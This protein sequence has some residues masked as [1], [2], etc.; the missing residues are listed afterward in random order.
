LIGP[1]TN[2]PH[3]LNLF[4]VGVNEDRKKDKIRNKKRKRNLSSGL[5]DVMS[6]NS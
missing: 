5:T 3:K 6:N 2:I 1:K 4:F